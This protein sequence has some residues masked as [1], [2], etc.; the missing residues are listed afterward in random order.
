MIYSFLK[1]KKMEEKDAKV[2]ET[3]FDMANN[4]FPEEF[5]ELELGVAGSKK[6]ER[7][8]K[9]EAEKKMQEEIKKKENEP[10]KILFLPNAKADVIKETDAKTYGRIHIFSVD[11]LIKTA[12]FIINFDALWKKVEVLTF[13]YSEAI[14][15]EKEEEKEKSEEIIK[16]CKKGAEESLETV[17]SLAIGCCNDVTNSMQF[18]CG[19]QMQKSTWLAPEKEKMEMLSRVI[20]REFPELESWR[21]TEPPNY[22]LKSESVKKESICSQTMD[23]YHNI[24][25]VYIVTTY[26]NSILDAVYEIQGIDPDENG[27]YACEPPEIKT[28]FDF[29]PLKTVYPVQLLNNRAETVIRFS[30]KL[31]PKD[32]KMMK[33]E[34]QKKNKT[35]DKDTEHIPDTFYLLA[36]SANSLYDKLLELDE[37]MS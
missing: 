24:L 5:S 6:K 16:V 17:K 18:L 8:E 19:E 30:R 2:A 25:V 4:A 22:P 26:I 27:R 3:I 13:K 31:S 9:K 37:K 20:K 10:E 32:G 34:F 23:A 14:S 7:K 12:M 11:C 1:K 21:S 28:I 33:E 29:F 15:N 36:L 35:S